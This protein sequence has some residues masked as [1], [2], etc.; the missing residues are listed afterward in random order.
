PPAVALWC[1]SDGCVCGLGDHGTHAAT[2]LCAD[3]RRGLRYGLGGSVSNVDID[4]NNTLPSTALGKD[5][6]ATVR[7][8][9]LPWELNV[10]IGAPFGSLRAWPDGPALP[11]ATVFAQAAGVHPDLA[12][13]APDFEQVVESRRGFRTGVD[14]C[15]K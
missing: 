3:G 4:G 6:A 5:Y 14:R 9:P 15:T 7:C 10:I 1:V 2:R 13:V 12:V 11:R 8:M